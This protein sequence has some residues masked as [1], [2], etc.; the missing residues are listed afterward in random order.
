MKRILIINKLFKDKAKA[1]FWLYTLPIQLVG[2]S[3][4]PIMAYNGDW[5]Y[6]WLSLIAY[7]LF[8]CVG[9]AIGLHR[10]WGH[11]AFEMPKWKERIMTTFS[12]F[13]G[14]GSIFPWVMIHERG[15]HKHSDREGDPIVLKRFL[16]CFFNMAQRTK[17][18]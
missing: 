4:L 12:V 6:L 10:Y 9:M 16:A 18:F 17:I 7:F 11:A 5:N 1:N 15:H 8:G 3:I 14:Y 13:N 2:W